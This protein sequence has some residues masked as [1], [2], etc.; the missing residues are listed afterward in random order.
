MAYNND[1]ESRYTDAVE[2]MAKQKEQVNPHDGE[3]R[4]FA[5]FEISRT[6]EPKAGDA[7]GSKYHHCSGIF[8]QFNVSPTS[9]DLDPYFFFADGD[10]KE[11]PRL[12]NDFNCVVNNGPSSSKDLNLKKRV[13]KDG[14]PLPYPTSVR[15]AVVRGPMILSGWGYDIAG[16]PVPRGRGGKDSNGATVAANAVNQDDR[17]FD[18]YT[19]VDRRRWK[20]GPVD[21]RWDDERKVWTGGAEFIE[22]M[23]T[24]D[25]AAGDLESPTWGSGQ[26]VRGEDW[27]F[28]TFTMTANKDAKIK[29]EPFGVPAGSF[30]GGSA[31]KELKEIVRIYNRN[32]NMTLSAGDYF[33]ATKINYE[34]RI[35]SAGGGGS[36]V[37]GKFKR[38]N[39]SDAVEKSSIPTPKFYKESNKSYMDFGPLKDKFVYF[40]QMDTFV[41]LIPMES[42]G[43]KVVTSLGKQ[44]IRAPKGESPFSFITV[45]AFE[46]CK[47]SS[48]VIT[49]KVLADGGFEKFN[50][51]KLEKLYDCPSST[52]CFGTVVDDM[53]GNTVY[54]IHPF[55]F[56]KHNVRVVACKSNLSVTCQKQKYGAYV[57]T[58]IDDCANAG[59][60]ESRE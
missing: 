7:N 10:R 33:A 22:G 27:K 3:D 16:L 15:A 19:P 37:V 54:A 21:L 60:G 20:T 9:F 11:D 49:F 53:N 30:L 42:A 38:V 36:C 5:A 12:V 18:Y 35:V 17:N 47:Y 45:V 43:G 57:I 26:I 13:D 39:C 44:E 56:I 55:K 24:S 52:D 29:P 34:W 40:L 59:T 28:K 14:K 51:R 1:Y 46:N 8:Y 48:N 32:P 50:E 25:L 58:E 2:P 23:M 6:S 41:D 4:V 31:S